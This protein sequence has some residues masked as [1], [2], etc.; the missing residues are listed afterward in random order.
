M[1]AVQTAVSDVHTDWVYWSGVLFR[2]KHK[3]ELQTKVDVILHR[4]A[5]RRPVGA[6]RTACVGIATSI[7]VLDM[8]HTVLTD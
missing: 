3:C 5:D 7:C 8:E 4:T 2:Q 1:C 6:V